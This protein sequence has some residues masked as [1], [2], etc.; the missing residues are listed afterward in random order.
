MQIHSVGER[1]INDQIEKLKAA[2]VKQP[3]PDAF[4]DPIKEFARA[5]R[6]ESMV[7]NW[8]TYPLEERKRLVKEQFVFIPRQ[9]GDVAQGVVPEAEQAFEGR[10]LERWRGLCVILQEE[11][12]VRMVNG[13]PTQGSVEV[14]T[15]ALK[16]LFYSADWKK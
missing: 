5:S 15:G 8:L 4:V 3:K 16:Q 7:R 1:V 2:H 14:A 10:M 13:K 9:M 12:R 6:T 11:S